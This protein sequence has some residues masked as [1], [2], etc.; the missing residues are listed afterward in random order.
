MKKAAMP[1][2]K[3]TVTKRKE[4]KVAQMKEVRENT[5]R[6]SS[7]STSWTTGD[8][9]RFLR[10]ARELI[11]ERRYEKKSFT[12]L[13]LLNVPDQEMSLFYQRYIE[14]C[15]HRSSWPA[16]DKETILEVAR[17]LLRDHI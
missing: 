5:T 1:V 6:S 4:K 3:K 8:E 11:A 9:I 15:R 16:M 13:E 7:G 17:K 14:T 2:T 10:S 12:P